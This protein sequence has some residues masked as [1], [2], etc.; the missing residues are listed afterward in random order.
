MDRLRERERNILRPRRLKAP[1]HVRLGHLHRVAI[2]QQRLH[3][4]Q[5]THLL[6]GGH[7]QRRLVGTGAED[8]ADAIAD[9][10]RCVE[11]DVGDPTARLGEAVS[12]THG[13]GLMQS[14]DVAEVRGQGAQHRQLGRAWVAEDRRHP[15]RA[16]EL[17]GCVAD[18]RHA[19]ARSS[20]RPAP[21]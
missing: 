4:D 11:V 16:E 13:H 8:R 2:G 19:H 3:R 21:G 9:A 20:G 7:E 14:Q 15:V 12:H 18:G 6:A 1:L 10:G 17:E 5:R